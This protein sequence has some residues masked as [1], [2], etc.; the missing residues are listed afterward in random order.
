VRLCV[1]VELIEGVRLEVRRLVSVADRDGVRDMV[2]GS[3]F[4]VVYEPE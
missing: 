1:K 2:S 4:D 3:V